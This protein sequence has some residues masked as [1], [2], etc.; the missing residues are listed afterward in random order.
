MKQWKPTISI[1]WK[2]KI[3]T[4]PTNPSRHTLLAVQWQAS[5]RLPTEFGVFALHAFEETLSGQEHI[6]LTMG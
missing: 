6:A 1:G 5:C 4:M 2:N 3:Q